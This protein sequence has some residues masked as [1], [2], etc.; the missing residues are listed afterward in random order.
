MAFQELADQIRQLQKAQGELRGDQSQQSAILGALD[1]LVQAIDAQRKRLPHAVAAGTVSFTM[2][3]TAVVGIT[4]TLPAG[5]FTAPPIATAN[6]ATGVGG[7]QYDVPRVYNSS[8]TALT[9]GV[10]TGGGASAASHGCR[11]DWTAVQMTESSA[12]G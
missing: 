8:T 9:I 10:W 11:V 4:A 2:S 3:G 1:G 6:L 7:S 5:K 12:A